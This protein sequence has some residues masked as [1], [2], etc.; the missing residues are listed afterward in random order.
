[1]VVRIYNCSAA[2][3]NNRLSQLTGMPVIFISGLRELQRIIDAQVEM[4][5]EAVRSTR[6][7]RQKTEWLRN[8][9]RFLIEEHQGELSNLFSIEM[10]QLRSRLLALKSM[11]KETADSIVL[12]A[13]RKPIFVVDAYTRRIFNRLGLFNEDISYDDMQNFFMTHLPPDLYLYNEY[14]ALIDGLGNTRC[15]NKRPNCEGCPLTNMCVFCWGE[16]LNGT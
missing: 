3:K 4:V 7:Y 11:G 16:V 1:M 2:E 13:A 12:Y 14:H 9:C 8:F 10:W 5:E 15:S 6:Y